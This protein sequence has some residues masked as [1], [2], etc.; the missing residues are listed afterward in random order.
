[1]KSVATKQ[2]LPYF[3]LNKKGKIRLEKAKI[4]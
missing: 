1:M 2:V 4:I 3:Y